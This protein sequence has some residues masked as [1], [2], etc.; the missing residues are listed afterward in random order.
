MKPETVLFLRSQLLEQIKTLSDVD[1]PTSSHKA[2]MQLL[3]RELAELEAD[4]LDRMYE[5]SLQQCLDRMKANG[6]FPV[7][8]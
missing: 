6:E 4:P 7:G 5:G 8:H 2:K 3:Q 1:R